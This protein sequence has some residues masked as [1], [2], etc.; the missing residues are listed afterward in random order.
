LN[1]HLIIP[2]FD[3]EQRAAGSGKRNGFGQFYDREMVHCGLDASNSR[4]VWKLRFDPLG[5]SSSQNE[6]QKDH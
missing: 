3:L 6:Q 5:R 1:E 2:A 4:A